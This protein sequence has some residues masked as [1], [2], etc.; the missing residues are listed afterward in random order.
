VLRFILSKGGPRS[1]KKRSI[2]SMNPFLHFGQTS[3]LILSFA[4]A[5]SFHE[6]VGFFHKGCPKVKFSFVEV[7]GLV[8]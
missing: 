2:T 4:K 6:I 7:N 8:L 1:G 5:I 3:G